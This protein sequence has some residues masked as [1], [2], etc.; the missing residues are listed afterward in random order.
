MNTHQKV[1]Q[2]MLSKKAGRAQ[3]LTTA[4]K[5]ETPSPIPR[6]PQPLHSHRTPEHHEGRADHRTS[7]TLL[8]YLQG[9]N[10]PQLLP[11]T[12]STPSLQKEVHRSHCP[13]MAWG[14]GSPAQSPQDVYCCHHQEAH[15]L[16]QTSSQ[17]A[18]A[19][20]PFFPARSLSTQQPLL[21]QA[22]TS[23][24]Q[25]CS[26]SFTARGRIQCHLCCRWDGSKHFLC[27]ATRSLQGTLCQQ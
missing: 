10:S 19:R 13:H 16:F 5:F 22:L 11:D 17:E 24:H 9:R 3:A 14:N 12:P 20:V 23:Q 25:H 8:I 26:F 2:Q 21:P 18:E 15:G 4:G 27:R 1:I 6:T 7:L